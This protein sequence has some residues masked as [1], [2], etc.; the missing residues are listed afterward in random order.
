[1]NSR[2][3]WGE[4]KGIFIIDLDV[5]HTSAEF[6]KILDDDR[7]I[8]FLLDLNENYI[9]IREQILSTAKF[10]KS[11]CIGLSGGRSEG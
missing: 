6:A 8:Q 7:V 4:P 3:S 5:S 9:N 1:M 10:G 11:L 2:D